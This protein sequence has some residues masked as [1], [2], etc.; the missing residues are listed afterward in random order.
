VVP[1]AIEGLVALGNTAITAQRLEL[2]LQ[3]HVLICRDLP[4]FG[5]MV[6]STLAVTSNHPRIKS[7]DW[8]GDQLTTGLCEC[9]T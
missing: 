6:C 7:R 8:N 9:V 3:A 2:T 1:S 5:A 4:R